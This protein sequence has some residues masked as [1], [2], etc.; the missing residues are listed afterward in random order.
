MSL[1][2]Y[3]P[4]KVSLKWLGLEM[5]DDIAE[6]TFVE[7]A[8]GKDAWTMFAGNDGVVVRI[9]QNDLSG[10]VSITVRRSSDLNRKLLAIA[11]ADR[12]TQASVGTLVGSDPSGPGAGS[13]IVAHDAFILA[14]PNFARMTNDVGSVVWRFGSSRIDE[15]ELGMAVTDVIA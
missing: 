15:A 4:K 1:K 3:D 6:G 2:T 7:V 5:N 10:V 8:K 13:G 11:Q 14:V 12:S 9:M